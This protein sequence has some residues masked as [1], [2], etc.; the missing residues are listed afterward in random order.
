MVHH[1]MNCLLSQVLDSNDRGK[2]HTGVKQWELVL[3]LIL[4]L[5]NWGQG[6]LRKTLSFFQY[7]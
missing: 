5:S 7:Q 6:A 2:K 1:T 3:D 4:L